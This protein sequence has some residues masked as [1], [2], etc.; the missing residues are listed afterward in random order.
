MDATKTDANNWKG[1]LGLIY[2]R[3]FNPETVLNFA[4]PFPGSEKPL[5]RHPS[6]NTSDRPTGS[7]TSSAPVMSKF[8]FTDRL[9][10]LTE[11]F[12]FSHQHSFEPDVTGVLLEKPHGNT[13]AQSWLVKPPRLSQFT[14]FTSVLW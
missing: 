1:K 2:A 14:R 3:L 8:S 6:I 11:A 4:L 13:L 7:F 9:F 5:V 10:D 12:F